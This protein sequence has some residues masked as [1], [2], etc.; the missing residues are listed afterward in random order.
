MTKSI[1]IY[2]EVY[3]I[4]DLMQDKDKSRNRT[5]GF[6]TCYNKERIR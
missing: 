4:F 6:H 2:A 3:V 1:E 5:D